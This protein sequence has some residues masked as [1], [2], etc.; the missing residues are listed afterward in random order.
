[1]GR[2]GPPP[3]PTALKL[4][5]GNPGKKPLPK[6]EAKPKIELPTQPRHLSAAARE[7]WDRLA[8]VLMRLGLLTR[9]DRAAFAAYCQAWG[10]YVE[11]EEMLSKASALAFTAS[12]YPIINPWATISKQAVEQMT[13]LLGEFGLTPAARTRINTGYQE[14]GAPGS[15]TPP[16]DGD[17][18]GEQGTGTFAF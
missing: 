2:R 13:R 4:V 9:L 10:R 18:D 1:M 14:P 5:A 3:K 8:P 12:G 6:N 16:P 11:A 7:E 17:G 15:P